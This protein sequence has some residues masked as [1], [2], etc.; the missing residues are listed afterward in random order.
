MSM[1]ETQKNN[2]ETD[3]LMDIREDL[4][5]LRKNVEISSDLNVYENLK[6]FNFGSILE[7]SKDWIKFKKDAQKRDEKWDYLE[8]NGIKFYDTK[9][10]ETQ[11]KKTPDDWYVYYMSGT[12]LYL[13]AFRNWN[14]AWKWIQINRD[15]DITSVT[16][17]Y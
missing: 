15:K 3:K 7:F 9:N 10:A 5:D 16:M 2:L 13:S 1:V 12:I 4:N 14:F 11:G 6:N 17:R 8:L